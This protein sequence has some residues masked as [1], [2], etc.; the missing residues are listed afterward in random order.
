MNC[1]VGDATGGSS[2]VLRG[3]F[4]FQFLFQQLY[5][6]EGS[7]VNGYHRVNTDRYLDI[8]K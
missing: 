8:A 2:C 6:A 4:L 7:T 5:G 1:D 3:Q